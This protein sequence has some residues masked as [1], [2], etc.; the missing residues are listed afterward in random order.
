MAT[1]NDLIKNIPDA[2]KLVKYWICIA[3]L[4]ADTSSV[5]EIIGIYEKAILAGA[6]PMEELR[7][8]IA[9]I[10]TTK[11]QEA[12]L[13]GKTE[14]ACGTKEETQE[15]DTEEKGLKQTPVKQEEESKHYSSVAFADC[16]EE[17][18]DKMKDSASDVLTPSTEAESSSIIKYSVSTTPYL[19]SAKKK[20]QF[21][22]T[23]SVFQ[24]LKFLTPVRRSRRIQE[25][26]SKLPDML[27]DHYP[28]VSLEQLS[29]LGN[30]T[31]A[32][33]YRPN[34]ALWPMYSETNAAEEE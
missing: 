32:F 2:K 17:Q 34:A 9:D 19:R 27:K 5:E 20:M 21:D 18:D 14:E 1:L 7:H 28:C 23:N 15:D 6:Q 10:L 3:K 26:T 12:N 31:D 8:V 4:E 22:E 24:E 16:E 11:T 33:V 30:E 25:K 13:G 29:E